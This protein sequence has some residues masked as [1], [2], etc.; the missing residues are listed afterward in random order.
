MPDLYL[1]GSLG[2]ADYRTRIYQQTPNRLLSL[3]GSYLNVARQWL[4]TIS[5]ARDTSNMSVMFDSGAF[6]AWSKGEPDPDVRTLL[7]IY[8]NALKWCLPKF[9]GV[10]FISLDKIPGAPGR[11]ATAEEIREAIRVSDD[12]HY[13]LKS[14]LGDCVLPVFHQ[15]EPESRLFEVV[16]LNPTYICVSPRN[17]VVEKARRTWSQRTHSLIPTVRTHGLAATGLAM[18]LEVPW[19][20]IDSAAW[21]ISSYGEIFLPGNE[22]LFHIMVSD[23]H[24]N[25]REWGKHLDTISSEVVSTIQN[26]C[27]KVEITLEELRTKSG[28]RE[29]FNVCVLRETSENVFRPVPI[30]QT[31]F[32]L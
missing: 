29:L 6:T 27:D 30:P 12:N 28:A 20:S 26:Y 16:E 18:M 9:K 17:D 23:Q 7:K 15:S 24:P 21:L 4:T 22:T 3:H 14:E 31:L 5:D 25:R 13:I 2:S 10:W 11:T 1:S 32:A 19:Q 8:K